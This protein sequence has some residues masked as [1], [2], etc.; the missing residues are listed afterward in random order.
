[1]FFQTDQTFFNPS[2]PIPAGNETAPAVIKLEK[3]PDKTSI[4]PVYACPS[5]QAYL[6]AETVAAHVRPDQPLPP[7]MSDRITTTAGHVRPDQP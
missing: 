5:T 2:T 3:S 1:M 6:N 4:T 7:V